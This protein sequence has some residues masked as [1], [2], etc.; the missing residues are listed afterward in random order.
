MEK[1]FSKEGAHI[2]GEKIYSKILGEGEMAQQ[3]RAL[4]ALVEDLSFVL[5]MCVRWL[6]NTCRALRDTM[7]SS[8]LH[9]YAQ[10]HMHIHNY[11]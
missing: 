7:P 1:H 6:T 11:K 8:D 3:L 2:S 10:T 5:S 9:T 4:T